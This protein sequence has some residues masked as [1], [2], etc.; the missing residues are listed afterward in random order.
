M[1]RCEVHPSLSGFLL[2]LINYFTFLPPLIL[3]LCIYLSFIP[4]GLVLEAF[5]PTGSDLYP[6]QIFRARTCGVDSFTLMAHH[7]ASFSTCLNRSQKL[8]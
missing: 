3:D 4:F 8:P 5:L 1:K 6:D 2:H 7:R